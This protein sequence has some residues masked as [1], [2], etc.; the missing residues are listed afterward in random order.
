MKHHHDDGAADRLILAATGE[1]EA[2]EEPCRDGCLDAAVR[3][4]QERRHALGT[5]KLLARL[6]IDGLGT[7]LTPHQILEAVE[8]I[9][10]STNDSAALYT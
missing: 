8:T 4:A 5:I 10:R 9:E 7:P 1:P 6:W 2:P 3:L